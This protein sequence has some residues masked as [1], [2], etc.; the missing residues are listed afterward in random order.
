MKKFKK[1]YIEITNICNLNCSFCPGHKR[2]LKEMCAAD[3]DKVMAKVH[4]KGENFY[5]HLMGEPTAHS[6]FDDILKIC[7]CYGIRPNI[8]TNGT[9]LAKRG[10]VKFVMIAGPS[11]SGKTTLSHRL[12]TQLR[13]HGLKPH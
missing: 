5:L 3:F 10:N 6:Q 7:N 4:D 12:S 1:I 8:T 11:S 13:T 9:L 2:N